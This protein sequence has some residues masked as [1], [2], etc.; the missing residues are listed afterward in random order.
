MEPKNLEI[1]KRETKSS[2]KYIINDSIYVDFNVVEYIDGGFTEK[3]VA[4]YMTSYSEPV[5]CLSYSYFRRADDG[6]VWRHY[7]VVCLLDRRVVVVVGRGGEA[8]ARR[9]AEVDGD[10]AAA[11]SEYIASRRDKIERFALEDFDE[12]A[13][14]ET[15]KVLK[16]AEIC[17]KAG[18]EVAEII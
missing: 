13:R 9:E 18:S 17:R 11:V 6:F 14:D 2:G 12:Y 16:F 4:T 15:M 5:T 7:G 10:C 3:A 1:K 8:P